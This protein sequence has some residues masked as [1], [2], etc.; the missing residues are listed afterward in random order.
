MALITS[1]VIAKMWQLCAIWVDRPR[2]N[3]NKP[4]DQFTIEQF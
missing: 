3:R 4:F 1:T 2:F